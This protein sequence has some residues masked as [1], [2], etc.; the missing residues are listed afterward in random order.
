MLAPE[1]RQAVARGLSLLGTSCASLGDFDKGEEILRLAIQYAG[2]GPTGA[3]VY[4]RL[5]VALLAHG[6]TGEA[7]GPLRRAAALG[8]EPNAVW[9]ALGR[10][11]LDRGRNLAALGA[12]IAGA[13]A[14]ASGESLGA[15]R[16]AAVDRLGPG[17]GAW[18]SLV[19]AS[20]GR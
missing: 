8:A 17:Y 7:I 6:R 10:A 19:G 12:A 15:V 2:D 13:R 3:D 14:G 1:A 20:G 18:A 9:P 11:F 4:L 5:G 16:E